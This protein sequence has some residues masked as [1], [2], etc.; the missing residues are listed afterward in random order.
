MKIRNI[1]LRRLAIIGIVPF[2]HT[3]L[4][5]LYLLLAYFK[6]DNTKVFG[7]VNQQIQIAWNKKK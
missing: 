3:I 1:H 6:R 4:F 2:T 7:E 5:I